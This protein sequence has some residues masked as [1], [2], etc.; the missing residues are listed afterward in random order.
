MTTARTYFFFGRMDTSIAGCLGVLGGELRPCAIIANRALILV[1]VP[2][3][4]PRR[5]SS[6]RVV[7]DSVGDEH[8]TA[9]RAAWH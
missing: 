4:Y 9:S 8:K 1:C 6:L 7:R 3:S 5:P 2:G